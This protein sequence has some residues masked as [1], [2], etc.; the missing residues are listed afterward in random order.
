MAESQIVTGYAQAV[1]TAARAEGVVD[2]VEDELFKLARTIEAAPDLSQRL[3]DPGTDVSEKASLAVELLSGRTHPQTVA[4][5][6]FVL[7][8][9]H[10][11]QLIEIADEVVRL[12]AQERARSVAE[13]RS[14]VPLDDAQR[15]RLSD[16]LART[17]GQTV[18]L[19]VVVDPHVVGGL[20]V[21]IGDTV[22]DG[23][24]SRRLAELKARLTGA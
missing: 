24:V 11:R 5:V 12:A 2:R 10:G 14:A 22:I 3:S 18:D 19:K 6:V 8:A 21:K 13:V 15:Q 1:L 4:A 23:S 16:A 7:Q 9:G 17:T 20:L